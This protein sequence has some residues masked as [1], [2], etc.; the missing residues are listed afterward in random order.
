MVKESY[1]GSIRYVNCR[2]IR[3]LY[4][5]TLE[6]AFCKHP[7]RVPVIG[8]KESVTSITKED[9]YT[10]YQAFYHPKN[11]FLV[12]TG[13]VDPKETIKIIKENQKRHQLRLSHQLLY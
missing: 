4:N 2:I 1:S 9:L 12:I 11:M 13:N 7:I 6:N 3:T 10:C 8:S 5:K